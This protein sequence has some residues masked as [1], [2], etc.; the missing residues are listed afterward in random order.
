V[1]LKEGDLVR[2]RAPRHKVD[3]DNEWYCKNW[4]ALTPM[5]L[6]RSK[7]IHHRPHIQGFCEVLTPDGSVR[8]VWWE[9]LTKNMRRHKK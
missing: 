1:V 7:I 3:I 4:E 6:L 2:L 8:T 9:N 5:V